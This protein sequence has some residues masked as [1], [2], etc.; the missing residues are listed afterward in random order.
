MS[1]P[2][3]VNTFNTHPA[4]TVLVESPLAPGLS[5]GAPPVGKKSGVTLCER[6]FLGH[7]LL[8]GGAIAFDKAMREV[9]GLSMPGKPLALVSDESGEYSVQWMSPDEWLLIVP[10][11]EE[12]VVENKLRA[13]MGNE[14]YAIT[15]VSG[16]QTLIELEGEKARELL[17]KSVVYDVHPDNFP[18]GKGVT[19]VF[20][21]ASVNLRRPTAGRW[22]LIVRRSFADYSWRW[23]LDAGEEYA[24]GVVAAGG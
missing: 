10:Q 9:L 1:E 4:S 14:H 6:P 19:T 20:A 21:K 17:M 22:E 7:L 8:R 16:G 15:N 3:L 12:F 13:V 18:P 24:I 5:C 23:L 11:G 2:Q